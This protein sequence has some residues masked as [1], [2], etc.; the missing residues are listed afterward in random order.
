M[1]QAVPISPCAIEA[2]YG[3][4]LE[5]FEEGRLLEDY[6]TGR[7][8]CR[9][10]S[11]A[12]WPPS[13]IHRKWFALAGGYSEDLFPGFYSDLDFSMKLWQIGCRR[14]WGTGS[15]LV[16]H[17]GE[18][19]T[20]LVRGQRKGNVKRSRKWFLKKWGMLPSTFRT[21]YLRAGEEWQ[22]LLPEPALSSGAFLWERMRTKVISAVA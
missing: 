4:D 10:W 19:T 17:F 9:D 13:A 22:A 6:H 14:F 16:Y 5:T 7:L 21:R 8:V 20:S 11:G 12:T 15:S 18:K 2:D 3:G 1:I